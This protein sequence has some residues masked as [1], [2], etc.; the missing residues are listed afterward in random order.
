V[1][2]ERGESRDFLKEI[3]GVWNLQAWELIRR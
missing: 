3:I 1:A 2:G